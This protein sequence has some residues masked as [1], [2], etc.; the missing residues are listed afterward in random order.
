MTNEQISNLWAFVRG[1]IE[2]KAFEAWFFG[3]NGFEFTLG[4]ELYFELLSADYQDRRDAIPKLREQLESVLEPLRNKRCECLKIKEMSAIDMGFDGYFE[5]VFEPLQEVVRYGEEK[6]WL[7]ISNC[8]V[9]RTNWLVAEDQRIY[10]AYFMKR[11][12][13]EAVALAQ[14]GQWPTE[15]QTWESVLSVGRKVSNPPLFFDRYSGSLVWS[16]QDLLNE[17]SDITKQEI[18]YLHGVP[19]GDAGVLRRKAKWRNFFGR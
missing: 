4:E 17:R 5:I 12:N 10:D 14:S 15:F 9:C 13:G 8:S 19:V 11:I 1:D 18:A 2:P 16:V 3:Q 7:S 6:W